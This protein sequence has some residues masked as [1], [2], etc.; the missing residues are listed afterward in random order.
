MNQLATVVG[1]AGWELVLLLFIIG[2]GFF[3]GIL[4][5][6][7]RIFLLL[8]SSYISFGLISVLPFKKIFPKMFYD[9]ENFVI[10]IIAFLVLIGII[11]V[12]LSRSLLKTAIRKKGRRNLFQIF[13]L[14][15]FLIGIIITVLFSFFPNDLISSFSLII[16]KIF[17]TSLARVLWLVIPLI[18]VGFFKK[19]RKYSR[20]I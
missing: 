5:G 7:D 6:R 20:E 3:L 4:L 18:F 9:E 12:L 1:V 10:L 14:C 13:F 17:N 11:Y 15:L 8:I 16:Q 19:K 2:G